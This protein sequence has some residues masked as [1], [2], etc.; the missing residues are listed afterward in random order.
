MTMHSNNGYYNNNQ[1]SANVDWGR[2]MR[3]Y[4]QDR[5]KHDKAFREAE[6]FWVTQR[7]N[8]ESDQMRPG[9]CPPRKSHRRMDEEQIEL[10]KDNH[11]NV[12]IAFDKYDNIPVERTGNE[13]DNIP[14]INT[15]A[16]IF[17]IFQMPQFAQDN[18]TLL[19]YTRPTPVQKYALPAGLCGRDLLCCAQTGSGKTASF[20]LPIVGILDQATAVENFKQT[21][22]GPAAPRTLI[23]AP[24]R[25]L[26]SQIYNEAV[27][28]THRSPFRVVQIYG[29][30]DAK[31]QLIQLTRG[32]DIMVATPGR[33]IDFIERGVVVL[34]QIKI[35]VLDEADRM[36]DMGF[37][38][39]IRKVVEQC[40]MPLERQTM[41]FS[42]T[43]E[44]EMQ[45]LAGD[46]LYNYVWVAVGQVGSVT[47][48]VTQS[49]VQIHNNADKPAE[50]LKIL[51]EELDTSQDPTKNP[52]I[53]VFVAKKRTAS[54][55]CQYLHRNGIP[56]CTEIHGDLSQGERERSL[57]LFRS[58]RCRI[59][60]ATD[61]A[62]RG[63]DI[64]DINLVVCYDA[65]NEVDTYVHRIGRGGRMGTESRAVTFWVSSRDD[66]VNGNSN[67]IKELVELLQ[68]A[69]VD[70]P[71]FLTNEY[72]EKYAR[73]GKGY[74]QKA[75]GAFTFG[76]RDYRQG[77]YGSGRR[78]PP[79]GMPNTGKGYGKGKGGQQNRPA[80]RVFEGQVSGQTF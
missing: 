68:T 40:D 21:F 78:G 13:I 26:C 12:G 18:V 66:P 51:K 62:A 41:M 60:C 64:P 30:V 72:N 6:F 65:P 69:Q 50:L 25:E 27:K 54:W 29:G 9:G 46:F 79:S 52:L 57:S 49:F 23:L 47:H 63:L 33:L 22:Q 15:F 71:E 36:L 17:D 31:T 80:P 24:T 76:G 16:E 53:M 2:K 42:A 73:S 28:F 74:N 32:V 11:G 10:F 7:R 8:L 34:N 70:V 44:K 4:E 43:F 56:E 75:Q 14:V 19:K 5:N 3:Q 35:L 37:E 20:I 59:L 45:K 61:V 39:Q 38:P 58:R 48:T 1:G 77:Q 55:L 67:I